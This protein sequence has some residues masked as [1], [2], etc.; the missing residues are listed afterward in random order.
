VLF[1]SVF[2]QDE[3]FTIIAIPV[4][5]VVTLAMV[6]M[7]FSVVW[8]NAVTGTGNSHFTFLIELI[9]LILYCIYV[10]V[11]L[12]KYKLSITIGWMSEWLYWLSIFGLSYWY[13]RSGRWKGKLI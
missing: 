3:A 12:E 6:L 2:G 8:M 9:T 11:V 4:V 10:Y 5:R 1:L 13:I 7:S